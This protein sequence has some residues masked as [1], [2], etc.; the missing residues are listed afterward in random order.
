MGVNVG[1]H[2]AQQIIQILGF[3][4]PT[5]SLR[6][7]DS[8]LRVTQKQTWMIFK[9]WAWLCFNKSLLMDIAI[10]ILFLPIGRYFSSFFFLYQSFKNIETVLRWQGTQKAMGSVWPGMVASQPLPRE[11]STHAHQLTCTGSAHQNFSWTLQ[12]RNN[13]KSP[14]R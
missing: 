5:V 12:T 10:L 9:Q 13:Q 2:T 7:L 11:T 4:G 14:R 6:C 1:I 8:T 3:A